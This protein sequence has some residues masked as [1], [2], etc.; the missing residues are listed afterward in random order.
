MAR[1]EDFPCCGHELGCCPDFDEET[2][3]QLNMI[4]VCGKIHRP[5]SLDRIY[6]LH[7][8]T[9]D[10]TQVTVALYAFDANDSITQV[11]N[12]HQAKHI[13]KVRPL[14]ADELPIVLTAINEY[15]NYHQFG[16]GKLKS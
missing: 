10:N 15:G 14:F 16:D 1:C 2:G 12:N 6:V 5:L 9:T 7:F 13:H 11:K 3:E 4:C 8:L